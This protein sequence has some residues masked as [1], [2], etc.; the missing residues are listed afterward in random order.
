MKKILTLLA[1]F[2]I[3]IA[4]TGCTKQVVFIDRTLE[5]T[6]L[7]FDNFVKSTGY[8]YKIKDD[9]NNIYNVH[10]MTYNMQYLLQSQPMISQDY[11]F[12]CKFKALNKGKDTLMD[13]KTY[14]MGSDTGYWTTRRYLKEQKWDD[15]KFVS[16]KKYK[17]ENL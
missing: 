7:S 17:K 12:T 14:P 10:I 8:N 3:G 16:Y 13:C 11:G 9:V 1:I 15:V 2:T 6:K 4:S 5:Q